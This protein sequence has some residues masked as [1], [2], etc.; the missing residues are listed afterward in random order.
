MSIAPSHSDP[1]D[2]V[3]ARIHDTYARWGKQT[4]IEQMRTDWDSLFTAQYRGN[5]KPVNANGVP[6]QWIEAPHVSAGHA[7][8]Y[9]H[10]GGFQVG[11]LKSHRE[12]MV[13]LSASS[14]ARVLG[15]DYRLTPEHRY[16][17]P[18]EDGLAAMQ[19]LRTQGYWGSNVAVAGDSAGG[20]LALA[21]LLAMQRKGH[22]MPSAGFVMSAWTDMTASGSSYDTR[23]ALDPIH[24]RPMMLALARNYL[25]K[26]QSPSEPLAS[27]IMASDEALATLPPLLLHVGERET[28]VSDS[29]DFASRVCSAGGTAECQVW[30]RMI[31]V[32]Q[33]YPEDLP[34]AKRALAAGG[35]F[36]AAQLGLTKDPGRNT[37]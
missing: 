4:P 34:E 8:L 31:H 16:P 11:S 22:P 10:G 23:S 9:L 18:L 26:E 35:K 33:Q 29:E 12:M 1:V 32:F 20:G 14:G 15:V 6:C 7:I 17:A 5:V 19:W 37:S 28:L 21:L 25:G 27:P 2:R 3:V 36:L 30:P 13:E 24:Q